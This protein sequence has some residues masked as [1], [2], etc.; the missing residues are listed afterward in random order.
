MSA[1]FQQLKLRSNSWIFQSETK[2]DWHLRCHTI[3][4]LKNEHLACFHSPCKHYYVNAIRHIDGGCI[5]TLRYVQNPHFSHIIEGHERENM[6]DDRCQWQSIGS[7]LWQFHFLVIWKCTV[8]QATTVHH[9]SIGHL[10]SQVLLLAQHC[11][12]STEVI[13]E[14][15]Q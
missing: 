15:T 3:S 9:I 8:L 4:M 10:Q 12:C 5:T 14:K 7:S 13:R 11:V 2:V 1:D 6:L